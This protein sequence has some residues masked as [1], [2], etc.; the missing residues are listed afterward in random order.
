MLFQ[1]ILCPKEIFQYIGYIS[2]YLSKLNSSQE[3]VS[4]IHFLNILSDIHFLNILSK[5]IYLI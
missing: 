2:G 1:N 5:K 3:L 4:D